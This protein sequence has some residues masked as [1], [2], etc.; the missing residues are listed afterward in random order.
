MEISTTWLPLNITLYLKA[1]S[2]F[3]S[4]GDGIKGTLGSSQSLLLVLIPG[5]IPSEA[6]KTLGIEPKSVT[7]TANTPPIS[8]AP[9]FD[10]F[11]YF[12]I[13]I[14][15]WAWNVFI[16]CIYHHITIVLSLSYVSLYYHYHIYLSLSFEHDMYLS[17]S[18]S[19]LNDHVLCGRGNWQDVTKNICLF[20]VKTGANFDWN[21]F[22]IILFTVFYVKII[23]ETEEITKILSYTWKI[24]KNK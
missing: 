13:Q 21:P 9:S 11:L 8:P 14:V 5:I 24:K 4:L 1:N 15:F 18:A 7:Y 16:I 2:W 17:W 22:V 12:L 6:Q 3:I 10:L 19:H 23:S 20:R